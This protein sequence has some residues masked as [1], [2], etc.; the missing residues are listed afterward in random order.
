MDLR[1]TVHM[2]IVF[3]QSPLEHTIIFTVSPDILPE[4]RR[5]VDN[6]FMT[7]TLPARIQMNSI[8]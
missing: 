6:S 4:N 1:A 5:W 8:L 7:I 2:S 3:V